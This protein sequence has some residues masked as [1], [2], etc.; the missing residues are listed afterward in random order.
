MQVALCINP[1][2]SLNHINCTGITTKS[3]AELYR[4]DRSVAINLDK[5]EEIVSADSDHAVRLTGGGEVPL[6]GNYRDDFKSRL[7]EQMA[8]ARNFNESRKK[9]QP[10]A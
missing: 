9:L 10:F 1:Q 4:A 5:I 3:R 7:E 2:H 8:S 6:S